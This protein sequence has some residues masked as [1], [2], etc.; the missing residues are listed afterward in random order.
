MKNRSLQVEFADEFGPLHASWSFPDGHSESPVPVVVL[1]TGDSPSGS[2]GQTWQNL[3]PML[4]SRGVGTF[5]FDFAGL[6][7]SPGVY[8]DLTLSVGCRN[9][10]A[11]MRYLKEDPRHDTTRVGV[12]GASYGGNVVLLEAAKYPEIKAI[13]LKSPSSFL[14]EGY[15]LQYGPDLMKA[16]GET[17]F[18][19]TVGLKYTAVIDSLFH[20][21]FAKAAKIE[22]P[23]RIVHGT[24]DTAVPIRHS[25]DLARIMPDVSLHEVEGA[26][27]WYAVGNEWQ[28]MADDLVDFVATHLRR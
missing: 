19:E 8:E 4:N 9:F 6:G 20:N 15:E 3:V 2:H 10:R 5:L 1:A 12:I 18:S 25:R 28:I 14:P 17:G 22:A 23:V 24:A 21:T 27:H 13:G 16:W 26:D 7:D 11:V